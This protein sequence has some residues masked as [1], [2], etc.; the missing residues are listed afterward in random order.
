MGLLS[1]GHKGT[2][3]FMQKAALVLPS[4]VPGDFENK[5][6]HDLVERTLNPK[7]A[8]R[9]SAT[10]AVEVIRQENPP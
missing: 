7:H 6:R 5:R 10:V 9:P 4:A 2:K 1:G 3:T 8:M